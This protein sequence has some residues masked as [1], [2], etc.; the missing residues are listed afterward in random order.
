MYRP[1]NK[2]VVFIHI[3]RCF[4]LIIRLIVLFFTYVCGHLVRF[5]TTLVITVI[6]LLLYH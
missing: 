4:I 1:S 3:T 6:T 2:Y 5:G